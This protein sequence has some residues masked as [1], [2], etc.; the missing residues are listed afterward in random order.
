LLNVHGIV[1]VATR[2]SNDL[3]YRGGQTAPGSST[4]RVW[5]TN[6]ASSVIDPSF[7]AEPTWPPVARRECSRVDRENGAR[8]HRVGLHG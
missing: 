7:T 1:E 2:A 3:I 8:E 4:W 5:E 6:L